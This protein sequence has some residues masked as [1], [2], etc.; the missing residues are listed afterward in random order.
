LETH[1]AT[2]AEGGYNNAADFGMFLDSPGLERLF[3]KMD[4][5]K[6]GVLNER[7]RQT[8]LWFHYWLAEQN[9]A[10]IDLE[11][12]DLE[13][14]TRKVMADLISSADARNL[15]RG[16]TS[17]GPS[18]DGKGPD[19]GKVPLFNGQGSTFVGW[20]TEIPGTCGASNQWQRNATIIR[21]LGRRYRGGR[22]PARGIPHRAKGR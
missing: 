16:R 2:L 20:G 17:F 22:E 9:R 14:F 13:G 4:K 18:T 21:H 12:I 8:L 3:A 11:T 10:K 7:N 5:A 19:A 1:I 6:D 15:A